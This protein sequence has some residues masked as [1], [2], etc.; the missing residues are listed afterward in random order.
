LQAV[1]RQ[2]QDAIKDV[3]RLVYELRPP[4]LDELGLVGALQENIARFA[5]FPVQFDFHLPEPLPELPAAV[6]VAAFRIVQ[7]AINN[8]VRHAQAKHCSI[9]LAMQAQS[10]VVEVSDDG[11]GLPVAT[12]R[13]G[14][15]LQSMQERA[16]ELDGS[17]S[18]DSK[19][20]HG[21]RIVANLP[22]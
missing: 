6:E 11:C 2:G 13:A 10:L 9:R 8:V 20:N 15:G 1:K 3:R 16:A 5:P 12:G 14:V 4:A 7:E 19:P 18:I 17:C 22:I 21:T